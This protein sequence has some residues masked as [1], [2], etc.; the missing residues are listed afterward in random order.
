MLSEESNTSLTLSDI[1]FYKPSFI[2]K[3]HGENGN[4]LATIHANGHVTMDESNAN[5][6][7]KIFWQN[8]HYHRPRC[9]NCNSDMTLV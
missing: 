8:I 9:P 6:A 1:T 7:A 2:M 3:I 4:T 5:V